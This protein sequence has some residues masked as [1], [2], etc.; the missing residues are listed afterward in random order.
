MVFA[1]LGTILDNWAPEGSGLAE[2]FTSGDSLE[3]DEELDVAIQNIEDVDHLKDQLQ[4]KLAKAADHVMSQIDDLAAIPLQHIPQNTKEYPYNSQQMN[5]IDLFDNGKFAAPF[6]DEFYTKAKDR[7]EAMFLGAIA[8]YVWSMYDVVV[9]TATG[10]LADQDRTISKQAC[11]LNLTGSEFHQFC[12]DG[13]AFFIYMDTEEAYTDVASYGTAP[14]VDD[15]ED[16]TGVPMEGAL[17][18]A[19]N[20]YNHYGYNS[21]FTQA[22]SAVMWFNPSTYTSD[23]QWNSP[24][25]IC[26]FDQIIRPRLDLKGS[27]ME[28]PVS[29]RYAAH[30]NP[31]PLTDLALGAGG[32]E[33]L[34][35]RC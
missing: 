26:D 2:I 7:A 18:S 30:S 29:G 6:P 11:D 23:T 31:I 35:G 25:T 34:E 9:A 10:T 12:V 33:V 14:G 5:A 32:F 21:T 16:I 28:D 17:K 19:L 20:L 13:R 27:G 24:F 3:I 1:V 8:A 4:S 15:F 22:T